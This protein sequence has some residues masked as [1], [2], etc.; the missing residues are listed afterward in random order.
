[1]EHI[2]IQAHVPF[3]KKNDNKNNTEHFTQ[4]KPAP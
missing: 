3:Q 2:N 1:M 4:E